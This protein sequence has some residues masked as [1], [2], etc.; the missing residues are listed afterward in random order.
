VIINCAPRQEHMALVAPHKEVVEL[1]IGETGS[2]H[3]IQ[4]KQHMKLDLP[5]CTSRWLEILYSVDID[6]CDLG[7]RP[8]SQARKVCDS[9]SNDCF[10]VAPTSWPTKA[11]VTMVLP[12]ELCQAASRSKGTTVGRPNGSK[13]SVFETLIMMGLESESDKVTVCSSISTLSRS[14]ESDMTACG[15]FPDLKSDLNEIHSFK[16]M[17]TRRTH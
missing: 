4:C 7:L 14:P 1:S 10:F 15:V 17:M 11:S 8:R 9:P 16:S 12:T 3:T 6:I 5:E 2:G 13:F